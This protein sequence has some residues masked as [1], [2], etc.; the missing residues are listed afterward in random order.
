MD[1]ILFKLFGT[2][3]HP[4]AAVKLSLGGTA[5]YFWSAIDLWWS[6]AR[7]IGSN[8]QKQTFGTN[9]HPIAAVKLS[10]GRTATYL[11]SAIDLG[12]SQGRFIG[13]NSHAACCLELGKL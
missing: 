4:I 8:R 9:E 1:Y 11:W 5:T 7:F 3:E 12:W 2:N 6:Q 13:F 10:L